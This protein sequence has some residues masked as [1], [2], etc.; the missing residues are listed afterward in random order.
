MGGILQ[1]YTFVLKHKAGVENKVADA[2]N[3]C[4]MIL[5]AMSTEVIGFQ[6]LREEYES[7]PD[8]G[9]IYVALR[10]GSVREMDRFLLHDRYLFMF[11]KLCIPRTSV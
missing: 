10:D 8:F 2:L 6:R 4:V 7:C 1:D 3:R 5:L 9:E 11:C